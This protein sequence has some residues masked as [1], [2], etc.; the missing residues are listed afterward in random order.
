VQATSGLSYLGLALWGAAFLWRRLAP[1]TG[2]PD[3]GSAKGALTEALP[4]E[5][6]RLGIAL[7][8]G[9]LIVAGAVQIGL[10]ARGGFLRRLEPGRSRAGRRAARA[11]GA[12]G[13]A[14]R[15]LV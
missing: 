1:G 15:G 12:I 9:G 2:A 8:G 14:A 3:G 10:A 6:R 7:L 13:I 4:P 5:L 11:L